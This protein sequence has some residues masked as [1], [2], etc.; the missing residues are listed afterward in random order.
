M[1]KAGDKVIL[2][3]DGGYSFREAKEAVGKEVTVAIAEENIIGVKFG[4]CNGVPTNLPWTY[5]K[6]E[7]KE[8]PNISKYVPR[9]GDKIK[10]LARRDKLNTAV[11]NDLVTTGDIVKVTEVLDGRI[12]QVN[13]MAGT[14]MLH[15]IFDYSTD[16]ELIE[17]PIIEIEAVD[18]G[19]VTMVPDE[20]YDIKI[21]GIY[22][23]TLNTIIGGE[24]AQ[25]KRFVDAVYKAKFGEEVE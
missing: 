16:F 1:V 7:F 20:D 3:N 24:I 12:R 9:V 10:I 25:L 8:V 18:F 13:N 22:G 19:A 14:S 23:E 21:L 2:L 11:V 6:G 15:S 4:S 17:R 5:K